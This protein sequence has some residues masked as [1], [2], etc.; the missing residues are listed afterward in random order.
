M[1]LDG[2][3]QSLRQDGSLDSAGT[4]TLNQAQAL[5]KLKHHQIANP[6]EFSA[7]LV[8]SAVACGAEWIAL[9]APVGGFRLEHNGASIP[10]AH[11]LCLFSSLLVSG[12]EP[13]L[14]PVQELA[15][16]LNA[17]LGLSPRRVRVTCSGPEELAVLELTPQQLVVKKSLPFETY[18]NVRRTTVEVE[19]LWKGVHLLR[20]GLGQRP[21]IEVL[22][23]RCRFAA[24]PITCSG[25]PL[26]FKEELPEAISVARLGSPPPLPGDWPA[27]QVAL[28]SDVSAWVGLCPGNPAGLTIVIHGVSFRVAEDL[29][30]VGLHAVLYAPNLRKDL[31]RA[32]IV[33]DG[34]YQHAVDQILESC[35]EL[36]DALSNNWR[37][38]PRGERALTAQ[39]LETEARRC[40]KQWQSERADRL[41]ATARA[42]RATS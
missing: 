2:Y 30:P 38:I 16:G 23:E 39:V 28:E 24:V 35:R 1:D 6:A 40:R 5:E 42:L 8:A 4:F 34:A 26:D 9:E 31:S 29:V 3:L 33:Q 25:Q 17:L 7:G 41:V 22:R 13:A 12:P 20:R 37:T 14:A 36:L 11:L 27:A 10:H 32:A 21:E 18:G 15:Y 19:G